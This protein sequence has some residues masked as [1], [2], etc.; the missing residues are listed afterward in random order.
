MSAS[1]DSPRT[2]S[3]PVTGYESHHDESIPDMLLGCRRRALLK[4]VI[5]GM[6]RE[7]PKAGEG[8]YSDDL[9]RNK[10]G[11]RDDKGVKRARHI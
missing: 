8:I 11:N 7:G 1:Q 9:G 4:S 2:A 5:M 10:Y 6:F 3:P